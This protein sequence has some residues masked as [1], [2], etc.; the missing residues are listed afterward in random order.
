MAESKPQRDWTTWV[1]FDNCIRFRAR[2][3]NK[4]RSFSL[5]RELLTITIQFAA[6]LLLGL[7]LAPFFI[8]LTA[9]GLLS[10][11]LVEAR[12]NARDQSVTQPRPQR[13]RRAPPSVPTNPE[14]GWLV[15]ASAAVVMFVL[16]CIGTRSL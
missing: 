13:P 7:Q 15:T 12:I 3:R 8:A 11:V 16:L 9:A 5:T 10:M 6:M 1:L 2:L 4:R 14:G